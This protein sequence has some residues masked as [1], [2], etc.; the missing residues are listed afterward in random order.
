MEPTPLRPM[1]VARR[2]GVRRPDRLHW[3]RRATEGR[4]DGPILIDGPAGLL[5]FEE[6]DRLA[7]RLAGRVPLIREAAANQSSTRAPERVPAARLA[8]AVLHLDVAVP[9]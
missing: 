9:A 1:S 3:K 6:C 2:R 5:A 7:G 4:G 8:L